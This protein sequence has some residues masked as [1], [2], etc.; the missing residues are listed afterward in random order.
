MEYLKNEYIFAFDF[1]SFV[2]KSYDPS[3]KTLSLLPRSDVNCFFFTQSISEAVAYILDKSVSS[4]ASYCFDH[5]FKRQ[6]INYE[7]IK[8]LIKNFTVNVCMEE[9][10]PS[11][12]LETCSFISELSAL[13]YIYGVCGA[14][15]YAIFCI[16]HI[17]SY[18][19]K[20]EQFFDFSWSEL[21][22]IAL[23]M[24]LT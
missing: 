20:H 24:K 11:T 6:Q 16:T 22:E 15:P 7:N 10:S 23:G 17:L 4:N 5:W 8:N 12:F 1:V 9:F 2:I 3:W 13:A 21:E 14:P 18:F 19:K